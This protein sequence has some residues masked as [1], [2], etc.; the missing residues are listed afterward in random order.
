MQEDTLKSQSFLS[1]ALLVWF[2]L[3]F[4]VLALF[5]LEDLINLLLFIQYSFFG[6]EVG[7]LDDQCIYLLGKQLSEV[8]A[9]DLFI[10]VKV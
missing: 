9:F 1:L 6:E 5:V 4:N 7:N 2:R 10:K 8:Q 3:Q